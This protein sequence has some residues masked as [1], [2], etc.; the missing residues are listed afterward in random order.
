MCAGK[1]WPCFQILT[2]ESKSKSPQINDYIVRDI[3]PS[4]RQENLYILGIVIVGGMTAYTAMCW[5]Q[6]GNK[7]PINTIMTDDHK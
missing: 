2:V 3:H 7:I 6:L 1:K 5:L 4:V